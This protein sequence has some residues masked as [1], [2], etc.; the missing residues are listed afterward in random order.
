MNGRAS[1]PTPMPAATPYEIHRQIGVCR[2]SHTD[3][4]NPAV[5]TTFEATA[6]NGLVAPKVI[7]NVSTA[8]STSTKMNADTVS[9]VSHGAGS[10]DGP[11]VSTGW[12]AAAGCFTLLGRRACEQVWGRPMEGWRLGLLAA[13]TT[14]LLFKSATA[15]CPHPDNLHLLHLGLTGLVALAAVYSSLAGI[16]FRKLRGTVPESPVRPASEPDLL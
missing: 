4:S 11:A 3:G 9:P 1:H 15:D 5:T 2:T 16:R 6:S 13:L 12:L 8:K 7:A 14:L 10:S